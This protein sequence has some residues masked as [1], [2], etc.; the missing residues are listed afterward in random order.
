MAK[1]KECIHC[2]V[3]AKDKTLGEFNPE[4][5]ARCKLFVKKRGFGAW[6]MGN[7]RAKPYIRKCTACGGEAH[8]VGEGCSYK[9]CPNCGAMMVGG[10]TLWMS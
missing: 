2:A 4:Q 10:A 8:F 3:C 7:D 1:C 6:T 9:L 5:E